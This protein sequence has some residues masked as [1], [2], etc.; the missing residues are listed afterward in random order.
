[1]GNGISLHVCQSAPLAV[2]KEAGALHE[3]SLVTHRAPLPRGDL[4][5]MLNLDDFVNRRVGDTVPSSPLPNDLA[6]SAYDNVG[7]V[8]SLG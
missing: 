5:Q 6:A 4:F 8:R 7:L 3:Q 1:M 2:L